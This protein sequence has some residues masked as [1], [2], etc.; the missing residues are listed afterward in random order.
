MHIFPLNRYIIFRKVSAFIILRV[1]AYFCFKKIHFFSKISAFHHF[2]GLCRNII[3]LDTIFH[4]NHVYFIFFV[5]LDKF[6]FYRPSKTGFH[7]N[8]SYTLGSFAIFF[9]IDPTFANS[10]L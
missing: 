2:K 6:L 4:T 8:V 7:K 5:S 9:Y 10:Q 1:Y 3:T